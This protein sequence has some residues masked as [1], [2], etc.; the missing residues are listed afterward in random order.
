MNSFP[1]TSNIDLKIINNELIIDNISVNFINKNM[2]DNTTLGEII[3]ILYKNEKLDIEKWNF[4]LKI[5][6]NK[7]NI[8]YNLIIQLNKSLY[9]KTNHFVYLNSNIRSYMNVNM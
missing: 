3:K 8:L 9:Y 4:L 6:N 2:K 1:S 5:I 7:S